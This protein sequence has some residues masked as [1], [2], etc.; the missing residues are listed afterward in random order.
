M[1]LKKTNGVGLKEKEKK[2]YNTRLSTCTYTDDRKLRMIKYCQGS[3]DSYFGQ[4]C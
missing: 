3:V 4:L 2:K 1:S